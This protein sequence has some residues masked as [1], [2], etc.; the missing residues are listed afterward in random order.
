MNSDIMI[1]YWGRRDGDW[2][3]NLPM[4]VADTA[5]SDQDQIILAL[6]AAMENG[7]LTS[8]RGSSTCRLCGKMNGY[9]EL[10]IIRGSI[11][12]RIP[13]GYLHYLEDHA[14]GY[15]QRLLEALEQ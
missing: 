3:D 12:Y 4:P 5:L 10:E 9:K 11:K 7:Y 15:D 1:G 13:E 8:Y 2:S 6:K 14:V